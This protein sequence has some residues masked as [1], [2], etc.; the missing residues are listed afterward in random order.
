MKK[1]LFPLLLLSGFFA[2][3]EQTEAKPNLYISCAA[4]AVFMFSLMRISSKLNK[5]NPDDDV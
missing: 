5:K 3:Y 1:L 2:L 4:F